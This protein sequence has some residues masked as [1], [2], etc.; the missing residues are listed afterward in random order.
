M[1]DAA[2]LSKVQ[3]LS[4]ADRL[5]LIGAV[6]ESLEPA[7][8]PVSDRERQL[9]DQRLADAE[10]NPEDQSDWP[11]VRDRLRSQLRRATQSSS[12]GPLNKMYQKPSNGMSHSNQVSDPHSWMSSTQRFRPLPSNRRCT[13]SSIGQSA[14]QC[15]IA[16]HISSGIELMSRRS[17][18]LHVHTE[19]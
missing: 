16:S 18:F 13:P 3:T 12:E 15:F 19:S 17:W 1:I 9:I 14:A 11:A 10:S 6:W 2:L 5:E 7:E 8:V 4:P